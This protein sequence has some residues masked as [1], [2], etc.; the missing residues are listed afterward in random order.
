LQLYF[1]NDARFNADN[2]AYQPL[3]LIFQA[4]RAIDKHLL[5]NA[6]Q[7][8]IPIAGL[9]VATLSSQGVKNPKIEWFNPYSKMLQSF[10]ESVTQIP[11]YVSDTFSQLSREGKVPSW[12]TNYLEID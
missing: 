6:N 2:F 12:A 4:L 11:D 10:D 7:N 9:G 3:V 1:P 8:A 5:E